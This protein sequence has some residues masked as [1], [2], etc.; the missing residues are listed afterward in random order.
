MKK[1]P[2]EKDKEILS[3]ALQKLEKNVATCQTAL[4]KSVTAF[5]QKSEE[6][7]MAFHDGRNGDDLFDLHA[8]VKIAR[9]TMKIRK[10]EYKVTKRH[11]KT[12]YK[13]AE[14][15]IKALATAAGEPKKEAD[16]ENKAAKPKKQKQNKE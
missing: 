8:Q 14:K 3:P 9:L 11:F 2:K 1:Q 4:D 6:Y 7:H 10:I 5:E 12:A 15:A 13:T 16:V